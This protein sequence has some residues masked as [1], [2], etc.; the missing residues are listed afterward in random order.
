MELRSTALAPALAASDR[1]EIAK[2]NFSDAERDLELYRRLV[3]AMACVF[4]AFLVA[5]LSS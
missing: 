3:F 4:C 5:A 1:C 2:A